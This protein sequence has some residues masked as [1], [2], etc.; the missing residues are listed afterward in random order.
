MR[1]G[2]RERD[3]HREKEKEIYNEREVNRDTERPRQGGI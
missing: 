2:E 1:E 3:R